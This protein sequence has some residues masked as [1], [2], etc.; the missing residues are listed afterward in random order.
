MEA[1]VSLFL[2]QGDNL[3]EFRLITDRPSPKVTFSLR[4][5]SGISELVTGR[6]CL[7][8]TRCRQSVRNRFDPE[9]TA[10]GATRI[11]IDQSRSRSSRAL[12]HLVIV[13]RRWE[14][15]VRS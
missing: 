2:L 1:R 13:R 4:M 15:T 9:Y 12:G 10:H 14:R 11:P 5:R 3:P 8:M 6:V 7:F